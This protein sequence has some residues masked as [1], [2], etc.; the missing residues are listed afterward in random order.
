M[1]LKH[2]PLSLW[3]VALLRSVV[4]LSVQP[5]FA[6]LLQFDIPV[7]VKSSLLRQALPFRAFFSSLDPRQ[8]RLQASKSFKGPKLVTCYS[9]ARVDLI[10]CA[11]KFHT[12]RRRVVRRVHTI[13]L[14]A[15]SKKNARFMCLCY[16]VLWVSVFSAR[17]FP[18]CRQRKI[19]ITKK[20]NHVTLTQVS[21]RKIFWI[22]SSSSR[23]TWFE[24]LMN[25]LGRKMSLTQ[26]IETRVSLSE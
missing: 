4:Q 3:L 18:H 7:Q 16:S 2:I 14:R 12:R 8:V 22:T 9:T 5:K 25:Q 21:L 26:G 23:F 10:N 1:T 15:R 19:Y 17:S 24:L 11:D 20:S 6:N 13:L